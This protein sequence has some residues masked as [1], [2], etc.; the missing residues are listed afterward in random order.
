MRLKHRNPSLVT[1]FASVMLCA[2]DVKAVNESAERLLTTGARTGNSGMAW[3]ADRTSLTANGAGPMLIEPVKGTIRLSNMGKASRV[4]IVPMDGAGR[5]MGPFVTAEKILDGFR[6][7]L[8]EYT[9]P[10]Y[11]IQVWR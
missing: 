8:G 5:A 10:W 4:E 2:L 9:T 3:N 1:P 6:V 7:S 11:L